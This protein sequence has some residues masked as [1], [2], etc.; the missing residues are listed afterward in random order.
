MRA[1]EVAQRFI[2]RINSKDVDGI[3]ALMTDAHRFRD[4]LGVEVVG[5]EKMRL[6]WEQYFRM[7]PDYDIEVRKS[8][9]DGDLGVLLGSARGTYSRSGP[10]RPQD[11]WETP[12]AWRVLVRGE[13]IAEWQG[14]ADHEPIRRIMRE[15]SA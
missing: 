1:V 13:R 10:L 8:I 7:V 11:A 4:S 5:R 15:Y 14:Y 12:A 2:D 6:A 9:C 3:V